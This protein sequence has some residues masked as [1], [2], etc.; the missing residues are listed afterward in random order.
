MGTQ[1][2]WLE[3]KHVST[4]ATKNFIQTRPRPFEREGIDSLVTKS[5]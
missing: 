2:L 3:N 1:F 4:G 5:R